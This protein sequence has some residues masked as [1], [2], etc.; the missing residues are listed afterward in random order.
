MTMD[1]SKLVTNYTA[2]TVRM[3]FRK[4]NWCEETHS[5]EP[6]GFVAAVVAVPTGAD[7]GIVEGNCYDDGEHVGNYRYMPSQKVSLTV[8]GLPEPDGV[9][10]Y[11]V[12]P[13]VAAVTDRDDVV[14]AAGNIHDYG[15]QNIGCDRLD[16]VVR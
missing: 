16:R 3:N 10:T 4:G 1:L 6:S 13:I 15:N 14:V 12:T 9:T 11:I 2:N 5:I 7:D 8:D